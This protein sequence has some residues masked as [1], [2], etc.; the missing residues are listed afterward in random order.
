VLVADDDEV[1]RMVVAAVFAKAGYDVL[2]ARDGEE[3]LRLACDRRPD[4]VVLDIEMPKLDGY[5]VM[6]RLRADARTSAIP[7]LLLTVR[8]DG[9]DVV[10]GFAAGGDDYLRKPF[11]G[12]E[13]RA[14]VLVLIER[15]KVVDRLTRQTR[16]DALTG[17][18]NRRAWE[19]EL[20]RELA[21]GA[22]FSQR[23]TVAML[24]LDRF[25][26]FNDER[27]HPAGDD[28]LREI[29]RI[30]PPLLREVDTIVRYGGE[31]FAVLLPSCGVE[32]AVE[33]VERLRAAVPG[34]QTC[35]AGIAEWHRGETAKRLM[36]RAD[37]ALYAAK[38]RGR[39][40]AVVHAHL[41]AGA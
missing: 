13:L 11:S 40:V 22:R 36:A 25:K 4:A 27:G 2:V 28:L 14:R 23:V 41:A 39:G 16:T 38:D 34:G 35:S 9:A 20:P 24:D 30:W 37:E 8:S 32:G 33:V 15:R 6:R 5:A 26:A 17:M 31:E 21:R 19:D 29:G 7:V 10:R 3:A 1:V 18:C 12:D